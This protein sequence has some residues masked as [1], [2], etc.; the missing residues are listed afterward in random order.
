M[1]NKFFPNVFK[2]KLK[3][4][5]RYLYGIF[6][7]LVSIFLLLSL[8]SFNIDDSSFLTNSS[9]QTR[10][11]MGMPG[12][13]LSSFLLYTFG[14]MAYLFVLF[15]VTYALKIFLNQ[16]PRYFFIKLLVFVISLLLIPQIMIHW[17]IQFSFIDN[18][19][20]WGLFSSKTYNLHNNEYISYF[21]SF[22]GI[23]ILLLSQ[24]FYS[25]LK[26][27]RINFKGLFSIKQNIDKKETAQKKEP[28][29]RNK[30]IRQQV[31]EDEKDENKNNQIHKD[32]YLSPSLDILEAKTEKPDKE[33]L[34]K[35]L[36]K[37]HN[38]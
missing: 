5:L 23:M 16:T 11:F 24:N 37:N 12:S 28:I 3:N 25:F 26:I 4:I 8:V 21:S 7:F 9:N 30:I 1:N 36:K 35:A 22:I 20:F 10:N 17:K 31:D 38:Y 6:F 33:N 29:I 13:Y 27:Q 18:L 32:K 14:I 15:F 2:D 19:N 34:K